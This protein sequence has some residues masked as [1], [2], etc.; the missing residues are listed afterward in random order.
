M[1]GINFENINNNSSRINAIEDIAA[2]TDVGGI[3]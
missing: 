2:A 1:L 3:I